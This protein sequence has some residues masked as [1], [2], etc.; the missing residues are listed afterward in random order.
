[1]HGQRFFRMRR[2]A[3]GYALGSVCFF[4]G[5]WPWYVALVGP[6]AANATF[7]VGS[8]LFAAAGAV[9]LLLTGRTPRR[10]FAT[11]GGVLDWSSAV[12]HLVGAA[13]FTVSTTAAVVAALETPD[14]DGI[15]WNAD[16]WGSAAFVLAGMLALAALQ[17]RHELWD[18]GARTPGTTWLTVFGS[19]AFATSTI[20]ASFVPQSVAIVGLGWPDV[21]TVVGAGCF[22]AAAVV[23]RPSVTAPEA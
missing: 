4:L 6:V 5:P 2:E 10:A 12:L 1:M 8:L 21:G 13:L 3:V 7:V 17:R 22:F 23:A 20:G 9:Q 15:G 16:A 18:M 11:R 14:A 19:L